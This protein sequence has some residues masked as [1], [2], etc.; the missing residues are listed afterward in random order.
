MS[1]KSHE[2]Q[3]EGTKPLR[4]PTSNH[5]RIWG[6][7]WKGWHRSALCVQGRGCHREGRGGRGGAVRSRPSNGRRGSRSGPAGLTK[8]GTAG[9]SGRQTEEVWRAT[10]EPRAS[11]SGGEAALSGA[12][13][14]MGFSETPEGFSKPPSLTGS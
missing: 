4:M 13:A 11:A 6:S 7:Q 1:P 9:G 8:A 2:K 12:A 5:V 10:G 3:V 14:E